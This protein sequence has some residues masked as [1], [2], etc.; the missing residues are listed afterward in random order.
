MAKI[1]LIPIINI[2]DVHDVAIREWLVQLD[3]TALEEHL[4]YPFR[5]ERFFSESARH[6]L[7]CVDEVHG[8]ILRLL[9]IIDP[10]AVFLD[11]PVDYIELENR[12]NR[13]QLSPAEFWSEYYQV[14]ATSSWAQAIYCIY[15]RGIIDK[16]VRLIESKDHLPMSVVFYGV[17][18]KTRKELIP[19]YENAFD[20]NGEFLLEIV[21]TIN[22]I[23]WQQKPPKHLWYSPME[24][25]KSAISYEE[26]EKFYNEL[27]SRLRGL[28]RFRV[29]S[30]FIKSLRVQ[31]LEYISAFERFLDHK[32]REEEIKKSNILDG[33]SVLSDQS[34]YSVIVL[35][36]GPMEYCALLDALKKEKALKELGFTLE[37]IDISPLLN[38][39]KPFLQKS[40]IMQNNY[41]IAL[42]ILGRK[43][44]EHFQNPCA[45]LVPTLLYTPRLT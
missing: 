16:N 32:M 39:M 1:F 26:T 27:L 36:S 9:D 11:I 4:E 10:Q 24:T 37:D 2:F 34:D 8:E 28:L 42:D 14:S 41:N 44:P 35:F 29:R 19:V 13:R 7:K 33:L 20:K 17:D 38:K 31:A 22:E 21:R 15:I 25:N 6:A 5:L 3:E 18:I 43:K 40:R 30:Y 12:Y 45:A 23:G